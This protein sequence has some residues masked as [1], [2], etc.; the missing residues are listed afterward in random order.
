[1]PPAVKVTHGHV[2]NAMRRAVLGSIVSRPTFETGNIKQMLAIA[3]REWVQCLTDLRAVEWG[4][5]SRGSNFTYAKS[6]PPFGVSIKQKKR[7]CNRDR[8]CPFCWA[9]NVTAELFFRL[10]RASKIFKIEKKEMWVT[11]FVYSRTFSTEK[12]LDLNKIVKLIKEDRNREIKQFRSH[13]AFFTHS[14]EPIPGKKALAFRRRGIILTEDEP[15]I[16]K[17]G[18]TTM[19]CCL[20]E[21]RAALAHITGSV[22]RY[23][24]HLLR[25]EASRVK[26]MLDNTTKCRVR[27]FSGVLRSI[28]PAK[29]NRRKNPNHEDTR[30]SC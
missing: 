20:P 3:R 6:C 17:L 8:I 1:M 7:C 25:A 26:T 29:P 24:A 23:P 28:L 15:V 13:G 16:R 30:R 12:G 22:T 18:H 10:E 21:N 4:P 9:R 27:A 2:Q 5:V 19:D 11:M 14:I